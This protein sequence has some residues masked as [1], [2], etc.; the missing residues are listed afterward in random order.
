[1]AKTN[2]ELLPVKQDVNLT[3]SEWQLITMLFRYSDIDGLKE[4]VNINE[5]TLESLLNQLKR[6]KLIRIS[7]AD[8]NESSARIPTF[9]W[10]KLERELSKSIGPI[11]SLVIDDKLEEFERSK[12]TFPHKL[13][14]SLVEKAAME[15]TA[16][17]EKNQFQRTMLEFIKQYL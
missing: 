14:Y 17:A 1:M 5:S 4:K 2:V 12:E 15:I 6:K 9:F 10:E 11:A 16:Q 3:S 13:L 8:S 7:Q